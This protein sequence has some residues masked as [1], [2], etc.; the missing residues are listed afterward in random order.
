MDEADI[1]FAWL[2]QRSVE[3]LEQLRDGDWDR[4]R[5]DWDDT[6]REKLPVEKLTELCQQLLRD[7]GV[8]RDIGQ[9]IVRQDGPY[10][11]AETPMS[12]EH[13][14]MKARVVFNRHAAVVGLFIVLPD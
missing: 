4:L 12:F 9:P 11:V 8:L 14:Q 3:I 7:A 10:R 1:D 13:G 2:A 5:A 6:M